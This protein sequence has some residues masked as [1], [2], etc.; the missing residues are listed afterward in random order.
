[1]T[2]TRKLLSPPKTNSSSTER[3]KCFLRRQKKNDKRYVDISLCVRF[4]EISSFCFL[5][6]FVESHHGGSINSLLV[7]FL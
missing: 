6:F 1:M 3:K 7:V 2:P 5:G 4:Q